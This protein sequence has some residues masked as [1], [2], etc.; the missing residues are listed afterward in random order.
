MSVEA[1]LKRLNVNDT[2]LGGIGDDHTSVYCR[3]LK[4]LNQL[5]RSASTSSAASV[6]E[7]LRQRYLTGREMVD[8]W[9]TVVRDLDLVE[10]MDALAVTPAAPATRRWSNAVEQVH[11]LVSCIIYDTIR[12]IHV[13]ALLRVV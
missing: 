3:A 4:S 8:W 1:V 9:T 7:A 11:S 10:D 13:V 5:A 6:K 12:T 2:V